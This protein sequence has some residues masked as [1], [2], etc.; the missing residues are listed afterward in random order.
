MQTSV[1]SI[2]SFPLAFDASCSSDDFSKQVIFIENND[3]MTESYLMISPDGRLFQNGGDEY[4]YSRPIT[5]VSLAEALTDIKFD[6]TKF[7]N[8]YEIKLTTD[9]VNEANAFFM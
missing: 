7:D 9:A 3:A 4:S 1:P 2:R 6:N 5:D 8:R